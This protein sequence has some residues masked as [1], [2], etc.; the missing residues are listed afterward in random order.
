LAAWERSA[1]VPE[2]STAATA[3]DRQNDLRGFKLM[4]KD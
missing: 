2:R 1:P 3:A 4:W